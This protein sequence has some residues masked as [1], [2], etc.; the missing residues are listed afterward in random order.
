ME[1][2][3]YPLSLYHESCRCPATSFTYYLYMPTLRASIQWRAQLVPAV[4][5]PFYWY[6]AEQLLPQI[7]D[8]YDGPGP[9]AFIE[10]LLDPNEP[11]DF[12]A[13]MAI[14]VAL[15]ARGTSLATLAQDVLVQAMNDGR[16]DSEI[17]AP[18]ARYWVD[19]KL[20]KISRWS[21]RLQ[22]IAA[23]SPLTATGV[24]NLLIAIIPGMETKTSGSFLELLYELCV[25]LEKGVEDESCRRF[26]VE[27]KGSGKAAKQARA[28]LNLE[29]K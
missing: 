7:E 3:L 1:P 13:A 9:D 14:F 26:L 2:G 24:R 23:D 18:A 16:V 17:L 15:T 27:I 19:R 12:P 4:H 21:K 5:G 28:I 29:K 20:P 10:P 11:I 25:T 22:T 6:G 8:S